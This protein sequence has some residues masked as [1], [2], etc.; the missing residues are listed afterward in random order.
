M[1]GLSYFFTVVLPVSCNAADDSGHLVGAR[2]DSTVAGFVLPALAA[3]YARYV[4]S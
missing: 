1:F 3:T 2:Q 4:R